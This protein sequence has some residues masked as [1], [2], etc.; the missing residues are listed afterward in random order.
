MI[1]GL[2]AQHVILVEFKDMFDVIVS[3]W[4]I[5][6]EHKKVGPK[7][8]VRKYVGTCDKEYGKKFYSA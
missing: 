3:S 6:G 5:K 2:M 8:L 4:L 1:C 7:K